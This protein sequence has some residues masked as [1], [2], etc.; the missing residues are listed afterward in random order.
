[1]TDARSQQAPTP[2][3]A[4]DPDIVIFVTDE[5]GVAVGAVERHGLGDAAAR[6]FGRKKDDVKADWN[7]TY[8]QMRF[9]LDNVPPDDKGFRAEEVTFELAFSAEGK[10]GFIAQA[11]LTASVSVTFKRQG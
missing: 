9:L 7:K 11:G 6:M 3:W 10:V 1:M 4:D 8:N 2:K 5:Q